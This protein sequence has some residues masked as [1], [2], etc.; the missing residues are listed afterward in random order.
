MS[1]QDF[2]TFCRIRYVPRV[3]PTL[4]PS[5]HA[6]VR[7][8]IEEL[9]EEFGDIPIATM[10][11]EDVETWWARLRGRE[12]PRA[13]R[14]DNMVL[15]RLQR[16]LVAAIRW[17]VR[18]DNPAAGCARARETRGRVA[19]L[20]HPTRKAILESVHGALKDFLWIA[21]YTA[22]RRR[23][24]WAL[25]ARDIDSVRGVLTFRN[26]KGS[27]WDLRVPIHPAL[28]PV[29]MGRAAQHPTGRL[30]PQWS[31]P[32]GVTRAWIRVRRSCGLE[33]F[34]LH[35]WRH[36]T[37]SWVVM[38]T[39]S[40]V[41]AQRLAGHSSPSMTNRYAHLADDVVRDAIEKSL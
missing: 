14:T 10:T 33:G 5:T 11:A 27:E 35:D 40:L 12:K 24:I 19:Y 41:A 18:T 32:R 9:I 13:G 22:A 36:D 26:P 28:A 6:T 20:D 31:D 37:L 8:E 38:G 23:Q 16:I 2:M 30:F 34:R 25:E 21:H 4:A 29:L 39:G 17:G 15:I 3:L 1:K 7:R